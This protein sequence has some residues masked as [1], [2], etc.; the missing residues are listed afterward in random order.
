MFLFWLFHDKNALAWTCF[1]RGRLKFLNIS[2]QNYFFKYFLTT[3][4]KIHHPF[5]RIVYAPC[6]KNIPID[7]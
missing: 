5:L 1:F 3:Q 2:I 4:T 6:R 7:L